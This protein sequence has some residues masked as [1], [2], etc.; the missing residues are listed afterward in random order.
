LLEDGKGGERFRTLRFYAN[1]AVHRQLDR[2]AVCLQM[3]EKAAVVFAECLHDSEVFVPAMARLL[4]FDALRH[5]A[6]QL[7]HEEGFKA[8]CF[9]GKARWEDFLRWVARIVMQRRLQWPAKMKSGSPAAEAFARMQAHLVPRWGAKSEIKWLALEEALFPNSA[10][11]E[12]QPK[13]LAFH[14]GLRLGERHCSLKG[15]VEP[16]LVL[17]HPHER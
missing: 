7:I 10:E 4:S 5:E 13:R 8:Q 1:W 17:R 9:E 14:I 3:L 2:D 15:P 12:V 6:I 11:F 16:C